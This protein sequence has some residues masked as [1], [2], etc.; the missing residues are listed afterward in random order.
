M[1]NSK[2]LTVIFLSIM[3]G[4]ASAEWKTTTEQIAKITHAIP[5][6]DKDLSYRSLAER[7]DNLGLVVEKIKLENVTKV[8]ADPPYY[9]AG[10]VVIEIYTNEPNEVISSICTSWKRVEII[11]RKGNYIALGRAANW[12]MNNKC[13]VPHH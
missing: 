6:N 5:I 4:S 13:S 11:K 1:A 3:T 8:D 2:I 7:L 10:D 9:L 12:L